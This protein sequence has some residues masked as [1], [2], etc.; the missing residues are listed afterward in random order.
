MLG[1]ANI[2][3]KI[4]NVTCNVI[5]LIFISLS[6]LP[7]TAKIGNEIQLYQHFS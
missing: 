2:M 4:F 7:N 3:I 5:L 1:K 6:D